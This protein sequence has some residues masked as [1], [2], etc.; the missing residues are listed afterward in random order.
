M[1]SS[2]GNRI[3]IDFNDI[4]F[5]QMNSHLVLGETVPD[6]SFLDNEWARCE[7]EAH[8]YW[9]DDSVYICQKWRNKEHHV[10]MKRGSIENIR[11]FKQ[12]LE[13]DINYFHKEIKRFWLIWQALDISNFDKWI[14]E[15]SDS[16]EGWIQNLK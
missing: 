10:C 5:E 9:N 6:L 8:F 2:E 13:F 14:Y 4:D 7:D 1:S 16:Y 11:E 15:M 12:E 3:T